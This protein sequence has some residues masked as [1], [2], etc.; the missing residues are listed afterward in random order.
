ML[1]M[2]PALRWAADNGHTETVKL[3]LDRGAKIHA[4]NDLCA[5]LWQQRMDIPRQLNYC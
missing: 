2:M 3:L 1:R 4:L 5:S